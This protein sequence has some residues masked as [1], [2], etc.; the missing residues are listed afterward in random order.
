MNPF[1]GSALSL[2][3]RGAWEAADSG[4]L[5]WRKNFAHF[6]PF[7]ALPVALAAFGLRFLPGNFMFSYLA[8]WWLRPLFDRLALHVVSVRFF[9]A[10]GPPPSRFREICKGLWGM[11]RGLLGDLLW[12]R[13]SLVRAGRMP[14]RVLERIGGAKFSQRKT[15]LAA[16][17]LDFCA[18]VSF[19]GLML[20]AFLLLSKAAFVLM[21]A[22]MFIPY[23][24]PQIGENM[25]IVENFIFAAFCLNYILVGSLYVCMGFGLYINS[26]V[27]VEGWDLQLLFQKFAASPAASRAGAPLK[28]GALSNDGAP[29]SGGTPASGGAPAND[30]SAAAAKSAALAKSAVLAK[31]MGAAALLL[32]LFL[33]LPQTAGADEEARSPASQL[34]SGQDGQDFLPACEAWLVKHAEA[35]ELLESILASPD[36]GEYRD[37]RGIGFRARAEREQPNRGRFGIP[38]QTGLEIRRALGY[39]VR[40]IVVLAIAG[41]AVFAIWWY[42]KYARGKARALLRNKG[43]CYVNPIFSPE[44]PESL[45]AKAENF[46]R[47]GTLREAWAACLAGCIGACARHR[48]VSFPV[49]ATEYGCLDLVRRALPAEAGGFGDLVQSW[50]LL[51]YGG[52]APGD[53]AFEKAIS[54][55]RSLLAAPAA[56]SAKA[57]AEA[58]AAPLTNAGGPVK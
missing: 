37:G 32:C 17:G 7:F 47:Q 8:L 18:F 16:G 4:I 31:S 19:L 49:D 55:G 33:A 56:A 58:W 39:V 52:R 36:F 30:A 43:K 53:G 34:L 25:D 46:F 10:G 45:F 24:L 48:A 9:S 57:S 11:R 40:A 5:L 26:R 2:R 42:L 1:F 20:E 15:A 6:I 54:Y 23:G 29:A 13:F 38:S 35:I 27:E 41:F 21:I 28:S 14:I 51:A 44:S 3:R 50:I 22:H 12:R